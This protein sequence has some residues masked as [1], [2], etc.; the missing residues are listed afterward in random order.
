[1]RRRAAC[2]RYRNRIKRIRCGE[3]FDHDGNV[4]GSD[5]ECTARGLVSRA[6]GAEISLGTYE[7]P[8]NPCGRTLAHGR[9]RLGQRADGLAYLVLE[10]VDRLAEVNG[11][12]FRTFSEDAKLG[13][14]PFDA[15]SDE[16]G[17]PVGARG[18]VKAGLL[19]KELPAIEAVAG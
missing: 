13:N 7:Q 6:A 12:A 17:A 16:S 19:G 10:L 9:A 3:P 14:A 2:R 4:S 1:M 8:P 11:I 18:K 15:A 5:L